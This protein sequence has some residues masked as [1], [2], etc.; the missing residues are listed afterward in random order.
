MADLVAIEGYCNSVEVK[1][2]ESRLEEKFRYKA[3]IPGKT[4]PI[5]SPLVFKAWTSQSHEP[6]SAN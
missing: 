4:A 2:E 5:H 1:P 3:S 6:K